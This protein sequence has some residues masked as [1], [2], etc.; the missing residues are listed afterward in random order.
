MF[1]KTTKIGDILRANE[2]LESVLLGFGMHCFCC[3][4]SQMETLEE[5]CLAHGVNVDF[6]VKTLNE[7]YE[8]FS[9]G[10]ACGCG[11][12]DDDCCCEEDDCDCGCCDD[13]CDC[14]DDCDDDCDCGCKD[15]K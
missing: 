6:A 3:P 1:D 9:K 5:A 11:C 15:N 13:D 12:C 4:M 7:A 2:N 14:E 8:E 10:C